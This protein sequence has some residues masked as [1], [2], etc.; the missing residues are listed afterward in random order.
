MGHPLLSIS[1]LGTKR[2]DGQTGLKAV[3]KRVH[4]TSFTVYHS[5]R[6]KVKGRKSRTKHCIK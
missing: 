1:H 3:S 2:R 5:I 4:R 6:D